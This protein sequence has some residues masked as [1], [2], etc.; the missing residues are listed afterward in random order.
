M[1]DFNRRCYEASSRK[2]ADE[3]ILPIHGNLLAQSDRAAPAGGL[4]PTSLTKTN[5][6]F[7][8]CR[9][10]TAQPLPVSPHGNSAFPI[11]SYNQATPGASQSKSKGTE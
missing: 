3:Q 7:Q 4:A 6:L 2:N 8:G 1:S 10:P 5:S 9:L 11:G